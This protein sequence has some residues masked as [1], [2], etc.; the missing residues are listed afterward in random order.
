MPTNF[1]FECESCAKRTLPA[2]CGGELIFNDTE[3]DARITYKIIFTD[4]FGN[5]YVIDSTPETNQQDDF[6]VDL[7]QLPDGLLNGF[8]GDFYLQV[9]EDYNDIEAQDIDILGVAYKCVILTFASVNGIDLTPT[10]N[11]L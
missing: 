7:S 5:E 3:L 1:A 9:K 6:S 11:P 4:K 10:L 8:S 2:I